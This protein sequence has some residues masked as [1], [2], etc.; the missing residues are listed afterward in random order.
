MRDRYGIAFVEGSFHGVANTSQTLRGL[1]R[2]L[3]A[4]GMDDLPER[5]EALICREEDKVAKSP[6]PLPGPLRR[7]RALLMCGGVK[8]WSL[9]GTLRDAGFEVV[10]TAIHKTSRRDRRKLLEVLEGDAFRLENWPGDSVVELLR[11]AKVDVV[12]GGG[13]P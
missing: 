9:A 10:G 1:S 7:K 3:A 5:T 12:L 4:Q 13:A 2:L 8:S 11:D 6:G